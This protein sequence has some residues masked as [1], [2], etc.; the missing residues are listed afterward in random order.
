MAKKEWE[1]AAKDRFL[2]CIRRTNS[3]NWVV[4]DED[5]PVG[6]TGGRNFDFLLGLGN[7]RMA[8]EL[9]RLTDDRRAVAAQYTWI[10][11]ATLIEK[12]FERRGIVGLGINS[13]PYF[14]VTKPARASYVKRICDKL[15]S[16]VRNLADGEEISLEGF[17]IAKFDGLQTNYSSRNY[18]YGF[19]NPVGK[20]Y[21]P[22]SRLLPEKNAQLDILGHERAVLIVSWA[23]IIA[24]AELTEAL[25]DIDLESL[26]NIDRIYFEPATDQFDLVFD[27]RA[28]HS[29]E[30]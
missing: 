28:L 8:L 10:E 22:L 20:A 27:R 4:V 26:C 24:T 29:R 2:G 14:S 12:E 30:R 6:N 7:R 17:R 1:Y 19:F 5:C 18:G 25:K 16:H 21:E 9:F 3:E 15:E 23:H 13:P 11:I